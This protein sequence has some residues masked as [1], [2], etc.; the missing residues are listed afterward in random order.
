MPTYDEQRREEA[1]RRIRE[2][3]A[4]ADR[5]RRCRDQRTA[6]LYASK[7]DATRECSATAERLFAINLELFRLVTEADGILAAH[8]FHMRAEPH[9]VSI[10]DILMS[11][12]ERLRGEESEQ[13][14]PNAWQRLG[15][16]DD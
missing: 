7:T 11:A 6:S 9:A 10:L 4:I 5:N 1:E 8:G 16:D 15:A 3:E 2:G 12:A 14:V 13:P